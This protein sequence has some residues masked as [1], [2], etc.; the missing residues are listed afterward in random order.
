MKSRNF[1]WLH[2]AFTFLLLLLFAL[3]TLIVDPCFHYHAPLS[4][5]GYILNDA[6]YQNDGITEHFSY[7]ALITGSSM[8]ENTLAS[9]V[10]S[11]FDVNSIKVCYEGGS[12]HEI[13]DNIRVG[14]T[15]NPELKTVFWGTDLT[16]LLQDK[17]ADFHGIEDYNYKYPWY[18]VDQ[19]PFNDVSYLF[20]KTIFLDKT[21]PAIQNIRGANES[22]SFDEYT[23]WANNGYI[24]EK[25]SVLLMY[26]RPDTAAAAQTPPTE[27]QLETVYGNVQQNIVQL[28]QDYP[29]VTFYIY[30]PPYNVLYWDM[31]IRNG[32]ADYYLK[33]QSILIEEC[34][35]VPNIK[36][37][38]YGTRKSLVTNLDLYMDT[39]HYTPKTN[40]KIFKW[41][42]KEK[43]LLTVDN[44]AEYLADFEDFYMNYD[45]ENIFKEEAK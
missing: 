30:I 8:T 28:A 26:D 42:K 39:T 22:T 10:D 20:N 19:N 27:E 24:F 35:K 44:Y 31:L 29:D 7:D 3:P 17:D 11:L 4:G 15:H 23:S 41:M 6:R 18:M 25:E 21:V 16:Y 37:Y 45:Y 43:G 32:D 14:L 36:L 12:Y 9:E 40:S 13:S 5:T 33:A 2:I 1:I 34:V 38:A